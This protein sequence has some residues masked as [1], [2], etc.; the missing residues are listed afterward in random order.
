[1]KPL[2]YRVQ[3]DG[4]RPSCRDCRFAVFGLDC[5]PICNQEK[6][7]QPATLS[8]SYSGGT[9]E[10]EDNLLFKCDDFGICD[11]LTV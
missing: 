10:W 4:T 6:Y 8:F 5:V 1:M 3:E 11:D 9:V 2:N 7:I